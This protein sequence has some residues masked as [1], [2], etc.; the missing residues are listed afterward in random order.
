MQDFD[1][2]TSILRGVYLEMLRDDPVAQR[3]RYVCFPSSGHEVL[4]V[5][6]NTMLQVKDGEIL[7]HRRQNGCLPPDRLAQEVLTDV[8]WPDRTPDLLLERAMK[9]SHFLEKYS[10]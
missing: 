5:N 9:I 1:L 10:L 4:I 8:L 3:I 6:G 2:D 7:S